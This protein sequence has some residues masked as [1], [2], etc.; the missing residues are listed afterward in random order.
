MLKEDLDEQNQP[1]NPA[2]NETIHQFLEAQRRHAKAQQYPPDTVF[3]CIRCGDCCRFNYYHLTIEDQRLLDRL[4]MLNKTPH[5]HW[6]LTPEGKFEGYMPVFK[7]KEIELVSF[8]GPIPETHVKFQMRTGRRHG[9]WVLAKGTDDIV[10]YYPVPCI[11]LIDRGP[12]MN[13]K[14]AIYKDRPEFCRG[15]IC[16][17]YPVNT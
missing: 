6:I 7:K 12:K 11:H 16:R 9:Y 17:R 10:V 5:G 2:L 1:S 3:K 4:Y 13:A 14:C 8:Q 15:Y